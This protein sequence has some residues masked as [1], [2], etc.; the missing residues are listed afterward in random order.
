MSISMRHSVLAALALAAVSTAA[1]AQSGVFHQFDGRYYEVV[2]ASRISWADANAAANARAHLGVQGHLATLNSEA[3]N[4][5]V[6]ALNVPP[7]GNRTE[8]WVG[9]IQ[10]DCTPEPECGWKWINDD[11]IT[12]TATFPMPFAAWHEG[13]PND[14]AK[15][16][17][18]ENRLVISHRDGVPG[19]ND[20]DDSGEIWGYVVEYGDRNIPFLATA[21]AAEVPGPGC[22]LVTLNEQPVTTL[23]LPPSAEFINPTQDTYEVRTWVVED[24]PQRCETDTPKPLD[25]IPDVMGPEFVGPE[26]IVP[27][28]LCTHPDN[29]KFLVMKTDSPVQIPSGVVAITNDTT[30]LLN[31]AYDCNA[32][33]P[34]GENPLEQ[35]VVVFQYDDKDLMLETGFRP[36]LDPLDGSVIE[37]TNGCINP[38][39]GSGGKGSYIFV[40]LSIH[41]GTALS[42]HQRLVDLVK[43]KLELLALAVDRASDDGAINQ[44]DASKLNGSVSAARGDIDNGNFGEALVH[45]RNFEKFMQA[46]VFSTTPDGEGGFRNW[47]GELL[48]RRDNIDFTLSVKVSPFAP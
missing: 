48:M 2:P 37:S 10:P 47:N 42:S 30:E 46:A 11:P 31:P 9:G 29:P 26:A 41:Q 6:Q 17:G 38:S 23:K 39:R 32:P 1:N 43:Y 35:D 21:C 25:L 27:G 14:D 24:D 44:G 40:G 22:P 3:E 36:G 28:Y 45:I 18:D 19:W 5:F 33:I 12:P 8:L 16:N 7:P 4:N 34:S 13:E 20:Q 15:R